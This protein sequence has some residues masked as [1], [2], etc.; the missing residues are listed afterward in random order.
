MEKTCLL[1]YDSHIFHRPKPAKC[2]NLFM[3]GRSKPEDQEGPNTL[4]KNRLISSDQAGKINVTGR[5]LE[6]RFA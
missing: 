6:K 4:L 2:S 3:C 5:N 1:V